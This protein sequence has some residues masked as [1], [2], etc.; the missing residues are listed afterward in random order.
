MYF[1]SRLQYSTPIVTHKTTWKMFIDRHLLLVFTI[2]FTCLLPKF[3]HGQTTDSLLTPKDIS[4]ITFEKV[5]VDGDIFYR[6]T[7][8]DEFIS[9]RKYMLFLQSQT[10]GTVL[11]ELHAGVEAIND[12]WLNDRVN[13]YRGISLTIPFQL[14]FNLKN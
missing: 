10:G 13:P 1:C 9:P 2:I 11:D 6:N 12:Y 4:D 7:T 3:S 14:K 8:T 5:I